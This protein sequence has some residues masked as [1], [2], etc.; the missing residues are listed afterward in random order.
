M[1]IENASRFSQR[2]QRSKVGILTSGGLCP[3]TKNITRTIVN[4]VRAQQIIGFNNG[5]RGLLTNG[6]THL[7]TGNL[8][9]DLGTSR[10]VFDPETIAFH[11]NIYDLETI[12]V[13][14]GEGSLAGASKLIE[15]TDT[16][17]V[18]L[19]KT[20]DNDIFGIDYSFGHNS[21][22]EETLRF[23]DSGY[24][25]ARSYNTV[26]VVKVM[27]RD[28]G[29]IALNSSLAHGDVDIT[30]VPEEDYNCDGILDRIRYTMLSK[31]SCLIVVAEGVDIC[32]MLLHRIPN[33]TG[34]H[35][36]YI[37]PGH[38]V[39]TCEANAYDKRYCNLLAKTAIDAIQETKES[40]V[41][42][43]KDGVIQQLPFDTLQCGMRKTLSSADINM[44]P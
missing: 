28:S 32:D 33:I 19:P 12:F 36:K 1:T 8:E 31:K 5:Y 39:R 29:F 22:V 40:F 44:L 30:L 21:A 9:Y 14:G 16:Q 7:R 24:I 15:H 42:G 27:G 26:S 2:L 20:I 34:K 4:N 6:Y 25:Q 23:I 3:G 37:E 35:V 38:F 41:V 10:V 11:L 43:Q 17:I 18:G 13:I